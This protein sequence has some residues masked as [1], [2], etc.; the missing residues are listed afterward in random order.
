MV[1]V[2]DVVTVV[3][4]VGLVD[5]VVCVT[6]FVSGSVVLGWKNCRC[7]ECAVV[8]SSSRLMY[9]VLVSSL[10]RFL[11]FFFIFFVFF[12]LGEEGET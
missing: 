4:L 7:F 11:V 9:D 12:G 1:V 3:V 2:G 5:A 10:I 6:P 8:G